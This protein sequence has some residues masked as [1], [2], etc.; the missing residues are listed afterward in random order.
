MTITMT[1]LLYVM[2]L[3][4]MVIYYD[5]KIIELQIKLMKN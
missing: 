3:E 2:S 4:M 1:V 5:L